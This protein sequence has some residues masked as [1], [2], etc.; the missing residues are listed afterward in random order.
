[1]PPTRVGVIFKT[2]NKYK[3]MNELDLSILKYYKEGKEMCGFEKGSP[4]DNLYNNGYLNGDLE[5]TSKGWDFIKN[6]KEWDS[7]IPYNNKNY[8]SVKVDL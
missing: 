7:V 8:I 4:W 1:M 3:K 5:L 2:L 6:Y